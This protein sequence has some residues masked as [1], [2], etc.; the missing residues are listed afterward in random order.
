MSKE[1]SPR[2]TVI[3][4]EKPLD[5]SV[6]KLVIEQLAVITISL[7]P[8]HWACFETFLF[9]PCNIS[10]PI[11]ISKILFRAYLLSSLLSLTRFIWLSHTWFF[12]TDSLHQGQLPVV[13]LPLP[14]MEAPS[15]LNAVFTPSSSQDLF[16]MNPT[17][18]LKLNW[19]L[20]NHHLQ[21]HIS[22]KIQQNLSHPL[23][24]NTTS[25]TQNGD[26]PKKVFIFL[27]PPLLP[28][29]IVTA[30]QICF[31]HWANYLVKTANS[32][33]LQRNMETPHRGTSH[34]LRY[35]Q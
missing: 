19:T 35:L 7:L 34:K 24:T 22:T 1:R 28:N 17:E 12:L 10:S 29:S 25:L 14:L 23:P 16:L 26:W 32:K 27:Y 4:T 33:C 6:T 13:T 5:L 20:K 18:K 8:T 21:I 31:H 11:I 2:W 15:L 9:C 3:F 30:E